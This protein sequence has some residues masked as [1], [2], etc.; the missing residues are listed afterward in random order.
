[1]CY[2]Q[3]DRRRRTARGN[4]V[5]PAN[6]K[7]RVLAER[8]ARKYILTAGLRQHRPQLSQRDRAKQGI[9][10]AEDPYAKKQPG[11]RKV[12]RDAS[13]CAEDSGADGITDDYRDA[14]A[15]A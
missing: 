5:A 9:E 13:G 6:N 8:V 2:Q 7:A 10:S 12:L 3:R 4:P 14:K 1:M 15:Y 11:M